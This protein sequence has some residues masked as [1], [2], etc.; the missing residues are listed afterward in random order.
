MIGSGSSGLRRAT[1]VVIVAAA[2]TPASCRKSPAGPGDLP[3]TSSFLQDDEGWNVVGDGVKVYAP[4]G[5][6][7]PSTGYLLAID[8]TEGETF[9][10]SAPGKFRGNVSAAY[11]RSLTFD[12]AWSEN[13]PS[14]YKDDDDIVLRSNALTI[15]AQLPALPGTTWTPYA[16]R[17]DESGGWVIQGTDQLASAAQIQSVLGSLQQLLIRGEFR[18]GPEEGKLDNVRLGA[19]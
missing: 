6:N 13:N 2:L 11:G 8:R 1:V 15:T 19:P 4:A 3:I 17:L 18:H 16:V 5:G 7:P 12:L 14:N 10:F 9:Y